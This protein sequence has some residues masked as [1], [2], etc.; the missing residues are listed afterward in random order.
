MLNKDFSINFSRISD[1]I[2]RHFFKDLDKYYAFDA[3]VRQAI[4]KRLFNLIL[5]HRHD[6]IL[7][8]G[9]SMGSIIAYD[10]L[11]QLPPNTAID[12][13]VTIGSPLGIPVIKGKMM[14]ERRLTNPNIKEVVT[15][16]SIRKR[17]FNLADIEDKVA[18]DYDLADDFLPN[19]RGV[20]PA[21][22]IVVNDYYKQDKRNPHKV[23]GYLRT[24][25]LAQILYDF[26][27]E[28]RAGMMVWLLKKWGGFVNRKY[29]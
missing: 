1:L 4:R 23:Y 20:Y 19:K 3:T 14:A 18:L 5:Q 13:L 27:T 8:I 10:V 16:D 21:Y 25:Q 26:I 7:I 11:S 2:I 29:L 17:W 9:H 28:K 6:K 22:E 12:T 24:P 15:P